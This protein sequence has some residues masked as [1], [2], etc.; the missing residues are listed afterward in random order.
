MGSIWPRF[1]WARA[2]SPLKKM[3]DTILAARP[4]V[5]FSLDMLTRNPLLIPCVTDKY[6]ATFPER[7]GLYPGPDA[8]D[9]A[10]EQTTEAAGLGG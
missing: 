1:R 10:R 4:D 7:N 2:C 5:K 3:M 9:G 8:P 6:W